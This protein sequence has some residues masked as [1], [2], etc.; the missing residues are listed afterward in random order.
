M[1]NRWFT[2]VHLLAYAAWQGG[3]RLVAADGWLALAMAS[4]AVG[5]VAGA[6]ASAVL[7][8][9]QVICWVLVLSL[10]LW[11]GMSEAQVERAAAARFNVYFASLLSDFRRIAL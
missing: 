3:G 5:Y 11:P 9:E 7:P 6:R 4:A 1:G 10:P 2:R 8:A